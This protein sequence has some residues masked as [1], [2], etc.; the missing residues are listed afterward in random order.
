MEGYFK[1]IRKG[2]SSF[3]SSEP[4]ANDSMKNHSR[5][6]IELNPDEIVSEPKIFEIKYRE[7]T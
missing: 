2:D 3:F 5:V 7:H 4:I 6:E 1:R